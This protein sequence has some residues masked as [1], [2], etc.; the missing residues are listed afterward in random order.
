MQ[1]RTAVRIAATLVVASKSAA[2]AVAGACTPA[3]EVASS[4]VR[5]VQDGNVT[6][7][8]AT[9]EKITAAAFGQRRKMSRGSLKEYIDSVNKVGLREEARAEE[10]TVEDYAALVNALNPYFLHFQCRHVYASSMTDPI[11][12]DT[13]NADGLL[14]HVRHESYGGFVDFVFG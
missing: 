12:T 3:P 14:L 4:V 9:M 7:D 8:F 2:S 1:A 5:L 10:L 11:K 13:W 6:G